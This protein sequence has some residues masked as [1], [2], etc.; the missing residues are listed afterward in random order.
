M[1]TLA[2]PI[3]FTNPKTVCSFTVE[4]VIVSLNSSATIKVNCFDSQGNNVGNKSL[5]MANTDYVQWG[6]DDTYIVSFVKTWL[7]LIDTL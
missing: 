3:T 7:A 1:E 4:S 6:T 2:T 5:T